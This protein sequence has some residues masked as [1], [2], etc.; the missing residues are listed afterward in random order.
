MVSIY[1]H[2]YLCYSSFTHMANAILRLLK[3]VFSEDRF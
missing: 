2:P 3:K 1:P